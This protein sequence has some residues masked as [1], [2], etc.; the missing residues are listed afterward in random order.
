MN[1]AADER[2]VRLRHDA[3]YLLILIHVQLL[4]DG[5]VE[6]SLLWDAVRAAAPAGAEWWMRLTGISRVREVLPTLPS[7][8]LKPAGRQHP[9]LRRQGDRQL[10]FLAARS[11]TN[12]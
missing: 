4:E 6:L 2:T 12:A 7:S 11:L 10:L 5:L 9:G 8:V 1:A 3:H